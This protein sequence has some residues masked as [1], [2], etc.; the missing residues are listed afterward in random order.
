MEIQLATAADIEAI[1]HVEIESKLQSFPELMESHDIDFET[2]AYR[3][4]TWFAKQSPASAMPQRI[5]FKV[6]DQDKMIGY[7]AVHLTSRYDKDA[8]IQSFYVLKEHQRG[9]IGT[10]LLKKATSWIMNH[11]AKSLCVGIT[12][13]NPYQQ[14]Y[15]QYGGSFL[16]PHWIVWD[17]IN[18]LK[19]KLE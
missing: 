14:F 9:G 4:K 18:L 7:L 10:A 19:S 13:E 8:E 1:T 16:N 17:D 5:V 2:R 3:W 6:I 12:P 11:N 15:L